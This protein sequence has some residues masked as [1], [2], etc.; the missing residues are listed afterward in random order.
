M[1]PLPL[2]RCYNVQHLAVKH[3][4]DLCC[5][6][7]H[8]AS[9]TTSAPPHPKLLPPLQSLCLH[10]LHIQYIH[11]LK[12][13]FPTL[14]AACMQWYAKNLR[15]LHKQSSKGPSDWLGDSLLQ[16]ATSLG[17]KW[18]FEIIF[19]MGKTWTKHSATPQSFQTSP[20]YHW[21]HP[22]FAFSQVSSD[23]LKHRSQRICSEILGFQLSQHDLNLN[24]SIEF[25]FMMYIVFFPIKK[26][27]NLSNFKNSPPR[28]DHQ[29]ECLE[30]STLRSFHDFTKTTT[31]RPRELQAP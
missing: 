6:L 19:N 10:I 26:H 29:Q 20:S 27:A 17:W 2:S 22:I 30:K 16:R 7:P 1:A 28:G 9:R 8:Q 13:Q 5:N 25:I 3:F 15:D 11:S 12:I 4:K 18:M 23:G 14:T 21:H 24:R 31:T